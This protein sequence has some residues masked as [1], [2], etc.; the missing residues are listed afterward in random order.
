[1]L[2]IVMPMLH[3]LMDKKLQHKLLI[4]LQRQLPVWSPHK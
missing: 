1:M 3:A 2:Q 4:L